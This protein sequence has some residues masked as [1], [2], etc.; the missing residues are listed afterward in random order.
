MRSR[1]FLALLAVYVIWG[2]TYWAI[3]VMLRTLPPLAT[4][5]L[6]FLVAGAIL[7]GVLRARGARWPSAREWGGAALVGV[8]LLSVGNG[9]IAWSEQ[10]VSSSLAAI[11]VSTV[12]LWVAVFSTAMGEPASRRDWLALAVGFGGVVWMNAGG[13]ILASGPKAFVIVLSPVAW[14]LGSIAARRVRLPACAMSTAAQM[15]AGGAALFAVGVGAGE[16]FVQVPSAASVAALAYLTVFGSI[17][18]FTAFGYLLRNARPALATS[19]AYVNPVIAVAIG[20]VLGGDRPAVHTLFGGAAVVAAVV[21]LSRARASAPR[22]VASR[23][24]E[25]CRPAVGLGP[26]A[27]QARQGG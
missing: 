18:G 12:P 20:T 26:L 10:W 19:Y 27:R 6:R 11:V 3:T 24:A 25:A 22:A 21:L 14:A 2:S 16:R 9:I 5:G 13:E 1:L 7:A 17:I 8:L 4:S 15:L 23:P